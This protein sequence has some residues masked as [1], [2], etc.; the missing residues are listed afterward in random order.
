MQLPLNEESQKLT[1]ISTREGLFQYTQF[2]YGIA[3]A[4][5][6]PQITMDKIL[7]GLNGVSCY[8]DEILV[9]G[10]DDTEHQNNFQ[11]V[12]KRLQQYGVNL[13]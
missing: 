7:Q 2:P 6:I 3:S 12:F 9:T 8:L 5:A 4:P 13:K 1:T 11:R 10:K